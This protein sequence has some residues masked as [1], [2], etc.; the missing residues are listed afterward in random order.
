MEK[1]QIGRVEGRWMS[2]LPPIQ[3]GKFR[4]MAEEDV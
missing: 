1:Y 3:G 4:L 2:F